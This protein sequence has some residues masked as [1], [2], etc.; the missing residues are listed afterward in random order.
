MI[1]RQIKCRVFLEGIQVPFNSVRLTMQQNSPGTLVIDLPPVRELFD[2][3]PRTFVQV[4]YDDGSGWKNFFEGEVVSHG[5]SKSPTGGRS[6]NLVCMDFSNYWL[7]SYAYYLSTKEPHQISLEDTVLFFAG[8]DPNTIANRRDSER[9]APIRTIGI[10]ARQLIRD[11]KNRDIVTG[12]RKAIELVSSINSFNSD[13]FARFRINDRL[14]NLPDSQVQF[15]V[16]GFSVEAITEEFFARPA[17]DSIFHMVTTSLSQLYHS[18]WSLSLPSMRAEEGVKKPVNFLALPTTFLTAP[19]RCNVIFPD[20]HEG[21]QYTRNFLD[22]PT[23]MQ[24]F[25]QSS[26]EGGTPQFHLAPAPFRDLLDTIRKA[27]RE[28]RDLRSMNLVVSSDNVE[29]DETIRG[30]IPAQSGLLQ[31]GFVRV[32]ASVLASV[33]DPE[34]AKVQASERIQKFFSEIAEYEFL[35]R[36]F[37]SRNLGPVQMPF[38]PNINPAFP[39]L[40]LD[41]EANLF[42]SPTSLVHMIS[43]DGAAA[44][45]VAC[46]MAR[47][48]DV[49]PDFRL[50]P[51]MNKSYIPEAIGSDTFSSV[52]PDGQTRSVAGAYPTLIGP[53]HRSI[54]SDELD[55]QEDEIVFRKPTTQEEAADALFGMYLRSGDRQAF[56]QDYTARPIMSMDEALAFLGITQT[57]DEQLDGT[58]YDSR[59]REVI[60]DMKAKLVTAGFAVAE[61]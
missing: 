23:R 53:G 32:R 51:W 14:Y 26:H 37:L 41:K 47:H 6:M 27:Q 5:F 16:D 7:F 44:T 4:F 18:L 57:N 58:V 24:V 10:K 35:I 1:V 48:K 45:S 50:P 38:N 20:L 8:A 40:I 46:A 25:G 17:L 39:I 13:R 55:F 42:A 22:E 52:D 43:A 19:P 30:I 29:Y 21:F 12:L 61:V 15:L 36:K 3:Y 33:K 28:G 60:N 34:K 56:V 31:D 49:I 54:L 11:S 59:K 2:I 9:I